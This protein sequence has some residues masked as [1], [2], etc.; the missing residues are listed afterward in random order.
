M[1]RLGLRV[2]P[3]VEHFKDATSSLVYVVSMFVCCLL[4]LLVFKLPRDDFS[5]LGGMML[6]GKIGS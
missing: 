6:S 2:V 3:I 5:F 1:H 4:I